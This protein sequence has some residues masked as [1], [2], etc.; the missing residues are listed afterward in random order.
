MSDINSIINPYDHTCI[1][2]VYGSKYCLDKEMLELHPLLTKQYIT[3]LV[4]YSHSCNFSVDSVNVKRK[5]NS[6]C[7]TSVAE[8]TLMIGFQEKIFSE[9]VI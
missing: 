4:Y 2:F 3:C 6:W 5:I 8:V 7:H 9:Q 1:H